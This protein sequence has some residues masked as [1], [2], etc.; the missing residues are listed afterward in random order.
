MF[1]ASSNL[2]VSGYLGPWI[3]DTYVSWI[4]G[5]Q[6]KNLEGESGSGKLNSVRNSVRLKSW[7]VSC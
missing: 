1:V 3:L 4:V 6:S 2:V 7:V 5:L